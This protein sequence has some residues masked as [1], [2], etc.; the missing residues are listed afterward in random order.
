MHKENDTP[1]YTQDFPL[2]L[3]IMVLRYIY[4]LMGEGL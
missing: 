2:H 1:I 3:F 4:S